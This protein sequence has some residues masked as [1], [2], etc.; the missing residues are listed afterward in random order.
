VSWFVSR[1]GRHTAAALVHDE[2][3]TDGMEFEARKRAD[4][5]F[6]QMLDDVDVPP[7][8]SRVM[9]TAATLATRRH[10]P[11]TVQA[12]MALWVL[13]AVAGIGLLMWGW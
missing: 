13:L 3:V 12:A 11:R 4:R 7:A 8:Q 1:Y 10:G 5:L 9:W 2:L 6:L